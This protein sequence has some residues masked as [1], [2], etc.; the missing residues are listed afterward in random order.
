MWNTI[1]N[2][3]ACC[4]SNCFVFMHVIKVWWDYKI[5]H[6]HC[7]KDKCL[8]CVIGNKDS[9]FLHFLCCFITL[10][11]LLSLITSLKCC[12]LKETESRLNFIMGFNDTYDSLFSVPTPLET[13][14]WEYGICGFKNAACKWL[15]SAEFTRLVHCCS[16]VWLTPRWLLYVTA[17]SRLQGHLK[18]MGILAVRKDTMQIL[19][20]HKVV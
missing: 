15:N 10:L 6:K 1:N 4:H 3:S 7:L 20:H 12:P 9:C 17:P 13:S 11:I 2:I 19:G 14:A 8:R 18:S 16:K 5:P